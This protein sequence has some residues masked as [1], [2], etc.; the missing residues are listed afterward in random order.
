MEDPIALRTEEIKVWTKLLPFA[1]S[2]PALAKQI[3]T[4]INFAGKRLDKLEAEKIAL[5]NEKIKRAEKAEGRTYTERQEA[6]KRK[7]QEEINAFKRTLKKQDEFIKGREDAV[8]K[9]RKLIKQIA[10]V[11][12]GTADLTAMGLPSFGQM[13]EAQKKGVVSTI[14]DQ[15]KFLEN[16]YKLDLVQGMEKTTTGYNWEDYDPTKGKITGQ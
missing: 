16:K 12:A 14:Q 7:Y 9:R 13:N 11:E 1:A 6:E 5:K 8:D 15:I 10:D 2:N 4:K 3:E